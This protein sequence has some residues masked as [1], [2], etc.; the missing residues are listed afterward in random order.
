MPRSHLQFLLAA[1][2][3]DGKLWQQ[4]GICQEARGEYPGAV[5]SFQKAIKVEPKQCESYVRLADV[6]RLRLD[7]AQEADDWMDKLVA[8]NPDSSQAHLLRARYLYLR[9][10]DREKLALSEA[11]KAAELD[12]KDTGALLLAANLCRLTADYDKAC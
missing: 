9:T 3:D 12:P 1:V 5:E 8:N 6:L 4:L 10:K 2:H 11:E 7:R